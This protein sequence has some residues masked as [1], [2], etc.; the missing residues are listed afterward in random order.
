MKKTKV[1]K[2]ENW[3]VATK[4]NNPPRGFG[5]T[6]IFTFPSKRNAVAFIKD[7]TRNNVEWMIAQEK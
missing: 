1:K 3:L 7:I 2:R 6:E 5:K 4:T